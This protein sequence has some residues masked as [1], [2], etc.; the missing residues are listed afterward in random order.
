METP[1]QIK[2]KGILALVSSFCTNKPSFTCFYGVLLSPIN[3]LFLVL[4]GG[5]NARST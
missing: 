4:Y 5:L 1:S 3:T 2:L